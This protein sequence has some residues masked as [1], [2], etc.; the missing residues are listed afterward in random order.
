MDNQGL[1]SANSGLQG[2][3]RYNGILLEKMKWC[4]VSVCVFLNKL[5]NPHF[6][7]IIYSATGI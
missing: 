1:Q 6:L 4:I 5:H 3:H 7:G 2:K